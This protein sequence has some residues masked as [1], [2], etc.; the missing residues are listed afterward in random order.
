MKKETTYADA[1][2]DDDDMCCELMNETEWKY[3]HNYYE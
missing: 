1:F 3:V 2:A